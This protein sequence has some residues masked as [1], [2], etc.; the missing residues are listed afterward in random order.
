MEQ[1][2][3][4]HHHHHHYHYY[5]NDPFPPG[6]PP[7]AQ[8][9][10]EPL[11]PEAAGRDDDEPSAEEDGEHSERGDTEDQHNPERAPAQSK[12]ISLEKAAT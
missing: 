9:N 8:G 6:L 12:R 1:H 3:V 11:N 7:N 5:Y 10:G 4:H 2:H